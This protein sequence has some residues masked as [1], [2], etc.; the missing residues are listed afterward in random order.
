MFCH[1]EKKLAKWQKLITKR[2]IEM[3]KL[4]HLSTIEVGCA[5]YSIVLFHTFVVTTQLELGPSP[6]VLSVPL[7]Y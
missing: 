3:M 6:I 7:P 5:L 4:P 1:F 2:T